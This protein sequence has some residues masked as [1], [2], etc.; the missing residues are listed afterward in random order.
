MALKVFYLILLVFSEKII[1]IFNFEAQHVNSSAC[2][3]IGNDGSPAVFV[4]YS[5]LLFG[6]ILSQIW[7]NSFSL[8]RMDHRTLFNG[9]R[10]VRSTLRASASFR[11]AFPFLRDSS[12]GKVTMLWFVSVCMFVSVCLIYRVCPCVWWHQTLSQMQFRRRPIS[13]SVIFSL[14][15]LLCLCFCF[16]FV[17]VLVCLFSLCFFCLVWLVISLPLLFFF[18]I[19]LCL[20]VIR[21]SCV[22]SFLFS[23]FFIWLHYANEFIGCVL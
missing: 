10:T 17:L 5:N 23:F 3:F 19:C 22:V 6:F 18:L 20:I 4:N 15:L 11:L 2:K 12:G 21:I 1:L 9:C 8:L 7:S 13:V 14:V 16:V